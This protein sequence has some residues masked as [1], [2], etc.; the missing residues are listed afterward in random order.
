[1][2]RL[3]AVVA[4]AGVAA[5]GTV[6]LREATQNRPDPVREGTAT[7]LTLQV[8]T[9]G[10]YPTLLGA[11]GLWGVCQQTVSES[12]LRRPLLDSGGGRF[13]VV[14]EPSLG[15]HATRRLRGCLEDATV[16]RV[17]ARVA[18]QR[19]LAISGG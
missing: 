5:G 6:G 19:D 17:S 11:Q 18:A 3:L 4:V 13:T 16:P 10:G 2:R 8:R 14:V 12:R 7:E 1:M 9:K 15:D